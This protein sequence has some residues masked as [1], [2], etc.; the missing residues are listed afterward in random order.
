MSRAANRLGSIAQQP[1][2][3]RSLT[4]PGAVAINMLDMI[5]VGPFIT[6]PLLLGAMGGPQAMLGWIF[7]ALLALAD[8]LVWAELAAMMPEAGGSYRFLREMFPGRVGRFLAFLFC[9]QLMFSAPL[10]VASGSIGLAQYA[11]YLW[12]DL[13]GHTL[14]WGRLAAGPATAVAVGCVVLVVMLLYRRLAN[15]RVISYALW[16]AVILTILWVLATGI[17]LGHWRLVSALPPGA[18]HLNR[19]FF[20]GLAAAMLIATYDFWGYYNVAFLAGEVRDASKNVPRAILI[21]IGIVAVLYIAMNA[22]LLALVPWQ[23]LLESA[24]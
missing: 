11:G 3:E 20:A 5:G 4:L 10:S 24:I 6:L 15:L 1:Q 8:G 7:G 19:A 9:F 17:W 18:F 23:T 13:R 2:L 21:S 14:H 16:G 22:A 12:P